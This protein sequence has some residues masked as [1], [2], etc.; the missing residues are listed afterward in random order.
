MPHKFSK[1][2]LKV[3]TETKTQTEIAEHIGRTRKTANLN[4]N[5]P[6]NMTI[7]MF[8]EICNFVGMNP[9]TC[10]VE[11]TASTVSN[12]RIVPDSIE[13]AKGE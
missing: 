1:E 3:F 7:G 10:F 4:I 8:L 5:N 9:A 6:E 2:R 13:I 11:D 12:R